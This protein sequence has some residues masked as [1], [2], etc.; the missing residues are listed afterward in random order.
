VL[1]SAAGA[2]YIKNKRTK[3]TVSQNGPPVYQMPSTPFDGGGNKARRPLE[4]PSAYDAG[5]H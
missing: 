3:H 1:S 5:A 2:F 4:P